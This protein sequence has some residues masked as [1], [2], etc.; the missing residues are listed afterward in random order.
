MEK[1][2]DTSFSEK[3]TRLEEIVKDIENGDCSLEDSLKLY[4]EGNKLIKEMSLTLEEAKK[5]V[6]EYQTIE[7]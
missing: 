6:K 1:N 7:E 5:K 3:L 4:E 2:K